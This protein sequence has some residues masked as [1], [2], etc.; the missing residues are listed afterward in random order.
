LV[1]FIFAF[2]LFLSA[3]LLFLLEPMFAKMVLPV[4]GGTPAVWNTCMVFYQAALLGGY[5]YAMF[6]TRRVGWRRQTFVHLGLLLIPLVILP[7]A[8]PA[9]WQP[10]TERNPVLWL[11]LVLAISVGLPFFTL[12]TIT[13]TLQK[14]F[15]STAHP[16]ARDPYFL[17]VASNC[18]SM[19]GLL[20]Y[21]LLV[22]PHLRLGE[23]SKLWAYGY[24]GLVMMMAICAVALW[25][26]PAPVG[27]DSV[28][29]I[30]T[31][32]VAQFATPQDFEVPDFARRLRWIALAF[33]PASLMLGVTTVLTTEVPPIP[34]LWVLPLA[35]YLLSFILVFAKKQIV[36]HDQMIDRLPFLVLAAL[37]PILSKTSLP[38]WID[39]VLNL[40]MLFV[41]AMVCHGE[42]ARTRPSTAHLT[43][44]YL[45][46][47]FGGVLGGLFNALLAPL[48]FSTALEFPLVLAAAASIRPVNSTKG[49]SSWAPWLDVIYPALLAISMIATIEIAGKS[50]LRPGRIL[51][52]IVFAPAML[53][54]LSFA[55]RRVRF[56]LG[57]VA[58]TIASMSYTGPYGRILHAERSF[59][60]IYHITDDPDGK[61]RLFFHGSTI[62]GM[63]S[64]S[65]AESREPLSY[66]TRSSP[67]GQVFAAFSGLEKLNHVAIVGLG[68]GSLGC[69]AESGQQF[70]FYEIDPVV[71]KLARDSRYFTFLRDCSPNSQIVLGDARLSLR[72]APNHQY[73]LMVLD[74]FGSDALPA[75]LITREAIELYLA[76]L[77]DDGA[78][79]FNISNRYLDL[80]PV[81][82]KLAKSEGLLCLVQDDTDVTEE[83]IQA[84]KFPSKWVVMARTKDSLGKLTR[85]PRWITPPDR[86]GMR[87]WSDDFSSVLTVLRWE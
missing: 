57:I 85:D 70:T 26:A 33:V 68:S 34:L 53:L 50:T 16:S 59:Y 46:L 30:P 61:Y 15:A 63:Q 74:A 29:E 14:W 31:P 18:G 58:L 64:L 47:S 35:I 44:F 17:Y 8:L 84:G 40:L 13:P 51:Q 6:V 73:G 1:L 19:L 41:A 28:P 67:I 86:P 75:H 3:A 24:Y 20:S 78:L 4:M 21:P 49:Q 38:V 52:L 12:A 11:L 27:Q 48:M 87:V 5:A 76:K 83:E 23:Q 71:E 55:K 45:W 79:I 32:A 60:G 80:Q 43:E 81:L 42:L 39:L 69:Y 56:A 37:I 72:N 54:C 22:E 77:K 66:F 10:P 65:S 9:G 2:T 36:P 82:C 25:R 7:I 62:H